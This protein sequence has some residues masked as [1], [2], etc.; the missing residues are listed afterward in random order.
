[1]Q[2][3]WLRAGNCADPGGK[4]VLQSGSQLTSSCL[5]SLLLS[6][7]KGILGAPR[8]VPGT[9]QSQGLCVPVLLFL[10][11]SSWLTPLAIFG[12]LSNILGRPSSDYLVEHS[13]LLLAILLL[14]YPPPDQGLDCTYSTTHEFSLLPACWLHEGGDLSHFIP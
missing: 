13:S 11:M 7:H 14:S 12:F 9:L 8:N 1:M 10:Q 6:Y 2:G 3:R 4:W 5:H